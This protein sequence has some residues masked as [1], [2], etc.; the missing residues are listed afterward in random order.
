[1][2]GHRILSQPRYVLFESSPIVLS[3]KQ[4]N[5]QTNKNAFMHELIG[6]FGDW[7]GSY[8]DLNH[9]IAGQ[10]FFALVNA[11][12]PIL[13]SGN[14]L[15]LLFFHPS[16]RSFVCSSF[17]GHQP[18]PFGSIFFRLSQ[19]LFGRRLVHVGWTS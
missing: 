13:F 14:S 12:S 9:E 2:Y 4:T 17:P 8:Y 3:H 16:I 18:N 5:K 7:I 11:L 19:M 6:V 1:M 10:S 15:T